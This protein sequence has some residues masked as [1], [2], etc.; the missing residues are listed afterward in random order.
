MSRYLVDKFLYRV[1]RDESEL[2]AYM[3]NPVAYV[4][5]W[6]KEEGP[7]L[8]KAERTSC[9]SFTEEERRALAQRDFEKLYAL[10]AHPFIL[11]TMMLPVY[12]KEFP[13]FR[14][15]VDH[16]NSKIRPYGRP[17]FST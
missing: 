15:L 6:E 3:E 10:G 11:W 12:E 4:A 13:N 14:A 5:N 1:D 17:D 9:H 7:W 16:Y 8:N 2:K